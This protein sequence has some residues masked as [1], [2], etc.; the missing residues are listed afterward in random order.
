M[1]SLEGKT[2]EIQFKNRREL[3]KC[4]LPEVELVRYSSE[5]DEP[6][7]AESSGGDSLSAWRQ[8]LMLNLMLNS[9]V[10]FTNYESSDDE[11]NYYGYDEYGYDEYGW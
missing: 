5:I 11:C 7:R 10:R 6:T 1:C 3:F 9:G 4:L 2:A 8:M